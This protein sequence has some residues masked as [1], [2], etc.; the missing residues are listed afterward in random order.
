M[1]RNTYLHC[2]EKSLQAFLPPQDIDKIIAD[3]EGFF[4]EGSANGVSENEVCN[5]L[6]SAIEVAKTIREGMADECLQYTKKMFRQRT[7]GGALLLAGLAIMLFDFGR[8]D[9]ISTH[10]AYILLVSGSIVL[11]VSFGVRLERLKA[12][13]CL[14]L[15][16]V[17]SG[18][19]RYIADYTALMNSMGINLEGIDEH[20]RSAIVGNLPWGLLYGVL[21]F[22][23]V[24]IMQRGAKHD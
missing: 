13:V 21:T 6:G 2:L 5:E 9:Y 18:V 23:V 24:T 14:S 12:R 8:L 22:V 10:I 1:T 11:A 15:L 20:V 16:P 4:D 3:Y 7:I 17:L 19:I